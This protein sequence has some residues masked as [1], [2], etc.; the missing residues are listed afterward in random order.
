MHLKEKLFV[1]A[2]TSYALQMTPAQSEEV[3]SHFY[4]P[5]VT[6]ETAPWFTGPLLA[7]AVHTVPAGHVDIEPYLT[8]TGITGAYND[9]WNAE[10]FPNFYSLNL[11]PLIW[12]GL[13]SFLDVNIGPQLI[14]QFTQ[15]ERSTQFGDIALGIDLQ[16]LNEQEDTWWPA[17]KVSLQANAP[18]GKFKNLDASKLGTDGAGSGNWQP[19]ATLAMGRLFQISKEHFLSPRFIF[20]YTVPNA[21]RIQNESVFGGVKGTEGTVYPGNNF[22]LDLGLEYNLARNWSLALDLRYQHWNKL[23]FSGKTG[24]VDGIPAIIKRPSAELFT[25]APALEYNWSSNIGLIGGAWFSV[26]GRN[27][28]RFVTGMLAFNV[29]I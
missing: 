18:T 29:Y 27:S 2:C 25:I 7:P 21:L 12:V 24:S 6:A 3:L 22:Y 13:T 1:L 28:A 9:H 15:G 26:A 4:T 5:A 10:S 20:T 19:G 8:F 23:R 17:I 16:L 14:Y 11:Q